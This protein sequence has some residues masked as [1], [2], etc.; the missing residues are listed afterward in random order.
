MLMGWE[1]EKGRGSEECILIDDT[2]KRRDGEE[3]RGN[4]KYRSSTLTTSIP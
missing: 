3:S 2:M 1:K 4:G